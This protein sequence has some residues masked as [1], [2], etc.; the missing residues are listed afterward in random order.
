M[1]V[2]TAYISGKFPQEGL[3]TLDEL[4]YEIESKHD[5]IFFSRVVIIDCS[6]FNTQSQLDL[7]EAKG[8][9]LTAEYL[10]DYMTS[11]GAS[12]DWIPDH[13]LLGLIKNQLRVLA[14]KEVYPHIIESDPRLWT[15][16]HSDQQAAMLDT[17]MELTDA[18]YYYEFDEIMEDIN[19]TN[20]FKK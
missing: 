1:G 6:E 18:H 16:E 17:I 5:S 8:V 15:N 11:L 20:T 19:E 10:L 3:E 13:M 12:G 7:G 14:R 2:K 9:K 4:G